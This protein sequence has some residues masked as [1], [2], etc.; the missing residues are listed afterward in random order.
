VLSI[1]F[2]ITLIIISI[3]LAITASS[4]AT[5]LFFSQNRFWDTV[6][7]DLAVSSEIA[8][9][10]IAGEMEVLKRDVRIVGTH[11]E[12]AGKPEIT[13]QLR[14]Y[15]NNG[16]YLS[17]AIF[18]R[19]GWVDF[20]GHAA[21]SNSYLENGYMKRAFAGETM[22]SP[23]EWESGGNLVMRIWEPLADGRVLIATIPG[24]TVSRKIASFKIWETGNIFVI[25]REGFVIANVRENWVT[26]RYNFIRMSETDPQFQ[27]PAAVVSRMIRGET[28]IGNFAINGLD[29]IVAYRPVDA[30]DGWALGVVAPIAESPVSQIGQVLLISSAVILGLGIIAAVFAARSVAVPYKKIE[31]QNIRLEELR[32]MAENASEAKSRFLA[33]MS[34]EMRTPLNAIIGLAEL[35]LG[36]ENLSGEI[37]DN[38]EQIY[39]SGMILLGIINDLLDISKIESG[40]F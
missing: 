10:M 12:L 25:D 11:L 35:E 13:E 6:R 34:H 21:P 23:P 29:R 33:N 32:E 4:L 20:Y 2:K 31:E 40:K 28:G 18:D 9:R 8:A 24:L 3:V 37:L 7:S 19:K 36:S 14:Y 39:N 22:I 17:L 16:P 27:S 1:R 30:S 26:Q 5:G 15:T 38:T